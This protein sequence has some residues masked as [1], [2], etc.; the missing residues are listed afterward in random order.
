MKQ[1]THQGGR[2]NKQ[3]KSRFQLKTQ[4]PKV[5]CKK[6]KEKIMFKNFY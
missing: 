3:E 4:K 1:K 2:E 5:G 6:A